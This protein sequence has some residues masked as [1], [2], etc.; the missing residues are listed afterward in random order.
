MRKQESG[1]ISGSCDV[2]STNF[3]TLFVESAPWLLL[4]FTLAGV[5][6]PYARRFIGSSVGSAW[7]AIRKSALLG[8]PLPLCSVVLFPWLWSAAQWCVGATTALISQ[9]QGGLCFISYAL[10]PFMA[11]IRP[12]A[13]VCGAI[14]AGVVV[15]RDTDRGYR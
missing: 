11:I 5:I 3:V 14:V 12:I 4:G 2:D 1:P 8:A 15:G 7:I 10:G 13:A 9:K 6:K